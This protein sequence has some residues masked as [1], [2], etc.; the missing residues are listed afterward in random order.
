MLQARFMGD[1]DWFRDSSRRAPK[2]TGEGLAA[3]RQE[4]ARRG[5]PVRRA[6]VEKTLQTHGLDAG[7][8]CMVLYDKQLGAGSLQL[9]YLHSS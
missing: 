1:A 6:Q 5:Q 7:K 2:L 3:L 9:C 8:E 4:M